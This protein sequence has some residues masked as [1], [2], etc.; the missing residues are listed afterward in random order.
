[1]TK[2]IVKSRTIWGVIIAALPTILPIFGV[3]LTKSDYELIATMGNQFI[4][5]TGS[6]LAIY[7]RYI[8]KQRLRIR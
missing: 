8:A 1:M 5:L 4:T 7:G 6:A 2:N 3:D